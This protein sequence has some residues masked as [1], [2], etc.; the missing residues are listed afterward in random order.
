M[1]TFEEQYQDV[2]Q[3]IE[4]A[5][6]SVYQERPE[7]T[8]W[9]VDAAMEALVRAYAAEAG[10]RTPPHARL[11]ETEQQVFERVRAMCEMRLGR[12]QLVVEKR[13][14]QN[15]VMEDMTPKTLDEIIAC[16]KRIRTSIKRWTKER[17]R[18]GYLSFIVQFNR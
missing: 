8:D 6:V 11:D 4:F 15:L 5:I 9:S 14:Q 1:A 18:Q 17:G 13:K 2:L 10:G 12:E 16:L 7:M 3:N